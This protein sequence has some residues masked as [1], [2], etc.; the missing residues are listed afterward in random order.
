MAN[1]PSSRACR[2][3]PARRWGSR[4]RHCRRPPALDPDTGGRVSRSWAWPSPA[5]CR[6]HSARLSPAASAALLTAAFS[7]GEIR[8]RSS[9]DSPE[10][11]SDGL[12]RR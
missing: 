6:T 5:R 3:P 1:G 12:T 8:T 11:D 10:S 9:G 2:E 7:S 4:S